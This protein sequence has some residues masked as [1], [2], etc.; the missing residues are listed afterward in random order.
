M[1][2]IVIVNWNS[3]SALQRCVRSI[4]QHAPE[5]ETLVV[6]NA[7]EDS[8][9]LDAESVAESITFIRNPS[10]LGF[11][12]GCN[13]GW[14]LTS[15][16][17]I[18]FLNPD[19]E[20]KAG[21]VDRLARALEM[22]SAA[23]AAGGALV[24]PSGKREASV[25]SFPTLGSVRAELLLLDQIWPQNPWTRRYRLLEWDHSS[26]R[27]VDQPAG[28]CLLV[29]RAML[30]KCEG[31]DERFHPAWFDDV[32]LCKRIRDLGGKILYISDAVFIHHGASSLNM[33]G[34]ENFLFHFHTNQIRYFRKHHGEGAAKTIRRWI[35]AG[36]RLRAL[37]G[38]LLPRA[39][40]ARR[41][42]DSR[43]YLRV[44]RRLAEAREELP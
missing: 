6:D 35:L 23:A 12:G 17:P 39:R 7:S 10:N 34:L 8:S 42:M 38:I 19:A 37:L 5:C 32:D 24:S 15:G 1:I 11:A 14:R 41:G 21:A 16:D 22:D 44:A 20:C 30:E 29:R 4:V 36:I 40:A 13:R 25:R 27:E 33:L 18:L 3:G 28:A 43:E 31:F 26:D 2:S 9:L